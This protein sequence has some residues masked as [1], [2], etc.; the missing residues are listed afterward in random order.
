MLIGGMQMG[1]IIEL[2]S[3]RR[4]MIEIEYTKNKEA[5]LNL[6]KSVLFFANNTSEKLYKTK[7]NKL[8][9]YTQFLYFKIY[10]EQLLDFSFIKDYHGP[11]MKQLDEYLDMFSKF[12]FIMLEKSGYGVVIQPNIILSRECYLPFEIKIMD[13]VLHKFDKFTAHEISEYSHR[14]PLW[15]NT[16]LKEKI[17]ISRACELNDFL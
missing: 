13:K 16:I 1:K 9:F 8:L 10:K 11:A 12:K 7:L 3:R 14:E 2:R 4:D 6:A 15:K 17:D 5:T